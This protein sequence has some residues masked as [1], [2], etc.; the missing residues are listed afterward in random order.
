MR[1]ALTSTVG[2][3]FVAALAGAEL[4]DAARERKA[5]EHYRAGQSALLSERL[6]QAELEFREATRLDPLL[7]AAHYGLGQVHMAQKRYPEAV[8]AY[9]ACRDAFE[10]EAATTALDAV[11]S[12]KRLDDQ[13]RAIRD[14]ITALQSGRISTVNTT[15]SIQRLTDQVSDLESRRHRSPGSVPQTPPGVSLALGSAYFR[16]QQTAD[17]E[18][19]YKAALAVSPGLGE[20][21]NNVAVVYML[22]GRLEA[23]AQEVALAEKAGFKVPPGLKQDIERRRA[24][25]GAVP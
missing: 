6:E 8:R 12:E 22:T 11:A 14:N 17:A 23:A 10:K 20:A 5:L 7:A 3:L 13:I 4:P 18:R 9:R 24:S 19:E 25:A 15:S 21:H 16:N 1:R 2:L